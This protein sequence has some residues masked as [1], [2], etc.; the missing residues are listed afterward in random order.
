MKRINRRAL[1]AGFI[2]TPLVIAFG[3]TPPTKQRY[4]LNYTVTISLA[5]RQNDDGSWERVLS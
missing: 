3:T 5:Y 2:G 4:K 1:L